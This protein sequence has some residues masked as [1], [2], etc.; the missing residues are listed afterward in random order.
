MKILLMLSLF[1]LTVAA[2]FAAQPV[3]AEVKWAQVSARSIE[4]EIKLGKTFHCV[5]A[6]QLEREDPNTKQCGDYIVRGLEYLGYRPVPGK[7]A[8][9][10]VVYSFSKNAPR[11]GRYET[12][13]RLVVF[14]GEKQIWNGSAICSSS[15]KYD[16]AGFLPGLTVAALQYLEKDGLGR[17][18]VG[19]HRDMLMHV[20]GK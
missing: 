20:N 12:L 1:V 7:E 9:F 8:A 14:Q 13:L 17:V 5:P 15:T 2:G 18:S 6:E 3:K 19:H 16:Y 4:K 11:K 10:R